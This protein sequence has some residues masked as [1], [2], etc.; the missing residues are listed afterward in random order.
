[1]GDLQSIHLKVTHC[2]N[3]VK[4]MLFSTVTKY[5]D[6]SKFTLERLDNFL[7]IYHYQYFYSYLDSIF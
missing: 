5:S 1:M 2:N 4:L 3:R 6:K 7:P